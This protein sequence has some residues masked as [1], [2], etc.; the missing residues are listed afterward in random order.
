MQKSILS[1]AALL[2]TMTVFLNACSGGGGGS[3]SGNDPTS[4][5]G[6]GAS[7]PTAASGTYTTK[8]NLVTVEGVDSERRGY[9][10]D[11]KQLIIEQYSGNPAV[12]SAAEVAARN[13][14]TSI[15]SAVLNQADTSGVVL[16][17]AQ[18]SACAADAAGPANVD[19]VVEAVNGVYARTFN[20]LERLAARKK[21][22]QAAKNAAVLK[23][24]LS[25]C[26]KSGGAQG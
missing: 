23:Y 21:F 10:D 18:S 19:A 13:F 14:Q 11:V 5:G 16:A 3:G 9:R 15:T 2:A 8:G 12:R 26:P 20:T 24:D 4:P 17:A 25:A 6:A 7:A 22:T 1:R